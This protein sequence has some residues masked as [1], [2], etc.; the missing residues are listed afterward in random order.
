MNNRLY[1]LIVSVIFFTSCSYIEQ[2]INGYDSENIIASVGDKHLYKKDLEGIVP[3]GTNS[4]DSATIVDAY[5]KRWA[6]E[7]LILENASNNIS[8]QAEIDKMVEEYRRKLII[9]YY[10]QNMVNQKI[11]Q[12]TNEEVNA[13]YN[14]N[15][16]LFILE[17]PIIKGALIKI[18]N[19]VKSDNIERKLKNLTENIEEI[20]KYALQYAQHYDLFIDTWRDIST[21]SD[22]E[23]VNIK[24]NKP[25]IYEGTDSLYKTIISVT[26]YMDQGEIAPIEKAQ[27]DVQFFFFNKQ[28]MQYIN[29]FEEE[30]YEY[31]I[32]QNQIIIRT[33]NK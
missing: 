31:G 8:N 13:F 20:E 17:E 28:K 32:H 22:L 18:P 2:Y 16:E 23:N 1:L 30:M 29:N 5:I 9:H 26:E 25:G 21:I 14:E 12:P 24:I 3:A 19:N 7:T 4:T 15:Q 11:K 33:N 27:K 6:A 10:Q